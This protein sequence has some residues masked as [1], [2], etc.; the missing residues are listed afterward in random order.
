MP[1]AKKYATA[2]AFRRA[3]EE[4]LKSASMNEQ[5]DLNRLRRQISFDRL[6]AN[7]GHRPNGAEYRRFCL[8]QEA[9]AVSL[10]TGSNSRSDC[11]MD[12][13]AAPLQ[14][15]SLSSRSSYG[16]TDL[17]PVPPRRRNWGRGVAA[18]RSDRLPG[19]AGLCRHPVQVQMIAREQ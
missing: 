13:T 1:P 17:R 5:T 14:R 10:G 9:A 8:L 3:L 15:R 12:L 18:A 19:L 4:R 6:L 16:Q 7:G 2:G 11:T